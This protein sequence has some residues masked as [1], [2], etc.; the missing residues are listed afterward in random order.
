M[1]VAQL[2]ERLAEMPG[3]AVVLLDSG[4]GLSAIGALEL[5]EDLGRGGR[6]EVILQP[7]MDE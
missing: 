6:A 2:L 4:A 5:V 1:T 7:S 3:N